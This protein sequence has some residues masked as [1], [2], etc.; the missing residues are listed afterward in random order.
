MSAAI[1]PPKTEFSQ[2]VRMVRADDV[3]V[4][5][6][7]QQLKQLIDKGANGVALIF[8]GAHNA[9][10]YGLPVR[11]DTIERLFDGM[12]LDGLHLRLD[13][14]PH[15]SSLSNQFVEFLQQNRAHPQ[16]VKITFSVDPTATLATCGKLRMSIAAL[17]A[18]LPQSM[19][20]FFASGQPGIVLE[21]D[22]RPYHDAGADD[23]QELGAMLCVADDHLNMVESGRH[24]AV[25]A[26][27]HIGFATALGGDFHASIVK[28]RVLQ[29]LWWRLQQMR[30]IE[31]PYAAPV[32]VETSRRMLVPYDLA[33]NH[34][35]NHCAAMAA[36][37]AGAVSLSLLPAST[38]LGLP[39]EA[40]RCDCLASQIVLT[41]ENPDLARH[42]AF[43]TNEEMDDLFERA[44]AHYQYFTQAG[45]VMACLIDGSLSRQLS[46]THHQRKERMQFSRTAPRRIQATRTGIYDET[47]LTVEIEGIY[48]CAP[49]APVFE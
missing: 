25:Q 40:E 39:D 26:L 7:N 1:I 12:A 49:L 6:A 24:P 37:A 23:A 46:K 44:F 35:R 33:L 45:G 36:V 10:G 5:R 19:S 30:G 13:N 14:H 48:H 11:D 27:P 4:A 16:R 32:H 42:A 47:P 34:A 2:T 20:A 38:P 18:S 43:I 29:R 22:G 15:G 8:E 17:R 9:Y 31:N 28:L 3:N 41:H 21:A